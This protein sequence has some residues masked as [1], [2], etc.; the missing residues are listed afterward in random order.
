[1]AAKKNSRDNFTKTV[2]RDLRDRVGGVCSNPDCAKRTLGPKSS[3]KN[4]AIKR[5]RAAHISAA[6]PGGPRYDASMTTEQRKSIDNAIWLCTDCADMIDTDEQSY[7]A[8]LL[9]S[10]KNR[11]E[12]IAA[13][14]LGK[15]IPN[16]NEA[17]SAFGI[18]SGQEPFDSNAIIPGVH[19]AYKQ[20][21][22]SLDPRLAV[23]VDYVGGSQNYTFEAKN[24]PVC[25]DLNYEHGKDIEL[26]ANIKDVFIHGGAVDVSDANLLIK[27]S[28]AFEFLHGGS[29]VQKMVV[30]NSE[31][32]LCQLEIFNKKSKVSEFRTISSGKMYKMPT[33]FNLALTMFNDLVSISCKGT[34]NSKPYNGS[35]KISLS[36]SIS[37]HLGVWEGIDI[38]SLKYFDESFLFCKLLA[39]KN[40]IN[41]N[42]I[43]QKTG[44]EFAAEFK[45]DSEIYS[46]LLLFLEY[47][48]LARTLAKY[49]DT[50]IPFNIDLKF[51]DNDLHSLKKYTA[52]IEN[53]FFEGKAAKRKS[54]LSLTFDGIDEN[55][56]ILTSMK[57]SSEPTEFRL[58]HKKHEFIDVAGINIKLPRQEILL[59]NIIPKIDKKA[60]IALGKSVPVKFYPA[61]G[62]FY[63][64]QFLPDD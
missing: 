49:F 63:R 62:Y 32:I 48:R 27:G 53:D 35:S 14:Q 59:H 46:D 50:E 42:F 45:I 6:A 2:V 34:L 39:E 17:L 22:E 60:K 56:N 16:H 13:R 4:K 21:L 38:K 31:D 1:M 57:N 9:R 43:L 8:S 44:M 55:I 15:S 28:P 23:N 29:S 51:S 52:I 24:G 10:W 20:K 25:L 40:T 19:N 5:G 3:D 26:D 58:C 41:A 18:L 47:W 37:F 36:S 33:G 30:G 12:N 54:V 61:A 64:I 7:P 11:T